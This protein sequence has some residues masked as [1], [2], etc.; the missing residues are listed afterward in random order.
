MT[1]FHILCGYSEEK[2]KL[3]RT[4]TAKVEEKDS[5]LE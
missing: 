3:L 4:I 5:E 1:M 2:A